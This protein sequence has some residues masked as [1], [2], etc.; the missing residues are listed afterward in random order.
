MPKN[1]WNGYGRF[2]P[3]ARALDVVGDRWT[4]VIVQ[5]LLKRSN[6][7]NDLARRLPGVS[8]TV[9]ADRLRKLETAGVVERR[10]RGIGDGV[11]YALTERGSALGDALEPLRRWGVAYL[12]DP[13]A[14]GADRHTFDV[15]YVDGIDAL[16]DIEFGLVVDDNPTTLQFAR[17]SLVHAPG[18]AG[19]PELTVHTSSSFMQRWA[20]GSASWDDGL[21]NGEVVLTGAV[22]AWPRWLAATGYLLAYEPAVDESTPVGEHA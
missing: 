11:E 19:H 9:L 6:R 15:R 7:Y 20:A 2:C 13:L 22:A 3:L 16:D 17:G 21:Q 1:A 5:E 12:T 10:P 18:K 4:L 8:T 14:D